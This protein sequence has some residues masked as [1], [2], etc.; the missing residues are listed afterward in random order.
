MSL[1]PPVLDDRRFDALVRDARDRLV[2]RFPEWTDFGPSDPGMALVDLFAWYT[3][4]LLHQ[5]AQLP[6]LHYFE[7]L[8]LLGMAPTPP[9]PS[10]AAVRFRL[11]KEAS[12]PIVVPAGTPSLTLAGPDGSRIG[13]QTTRELGVV[14]RPLVRLVRDLPTTPEDAE[15]AGDLAALAAPD[16]PGFHPFGRLGEVGSTL[17]L[18]FQASADTAAT[19]VFP[20]VV[21]LYVRP[22]DETAAPPPTAEIR[23]K[24]PAPAPAG[25]V[26]PM[27]EIVA[28]AVV[29]DRE[30]EPLDIL[31]ESDA[32]GFDRAGYLHLRGPRRARPRPWPDTR[33][34]GGEAVPCL[35]IGLRVTGASFPYDR[36]P[37][38]RLLTDAVEAVA[39]E[40]VVFREVGVSTGLA[41]QRFTLRNPPVE[42]ESLELV[43]VRDSGPSGDRRAMADRAE[44]WRVVDDFA[45]SGSRDE[46]VVVDATTGEL[47]FGDSVTGAIP[48]AGRRIIA[49]RYRR[50]GGAVTNVAAD[51]VR[52]EPFRGVVGTNPFAAEGGRDAEAA[53]ARAARAPRRL[54]DLGREHRAGCRRHGAGQGRARAPPGL[55]ARP[56]AGGADRRCGAADHAPWP[57]SAVSGPCRRRPPR[58]RAGGAPAVGPGAVRPPGRRRARQGSCGRAGRARHPAAR[59]RGRR[60]RPA[61]HGDQRRRARLRRRAPSADAGGRVAGA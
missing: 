17:Y 57:P 22:V 49:R 47:R 56:P 29:G 35:W 10:R 48:H 24:P 41:D 28:F 20:E 60:P 53:E 61:R 33:A 43:V 34:G 1:R 19:N 11:P 54:R 42:P 40:T 12:A 8:E 45:H 7:F 15:P 51:K 55:S 44:P 37:M 9:A 58:G 2:Q 31:A 39:R 52:F 30:T 23:G 59:G 21:S 25:G 3:E 36:A 46:H 27:P 26:Y 13:F 4:T 32:A 5:M 6:A 16:G 38:I 50:G 14:A 18:G